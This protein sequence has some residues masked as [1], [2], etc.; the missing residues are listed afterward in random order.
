[1]ISRTDGMALLIHHVASGQAFFSGVALIL[2]AVASASAGC[3]W[4]I[5]RP[6]SPEPSR[7]EIAICVGQRGFPIVDTVLALADLAGVVYVASE[8]NIDAKGTRIV[9]GT[10]LA[11]LWALSAEYG[12]RLTGE[13]RAAQEQR[14]VSTT[15]AGAS[16]HA[17]GPTA[18]TGRGQPAASA[19]SHSFAG[20]GQPADS[21]LATTD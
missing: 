6:L 4:L 16:S 7:R 14:L 5:V 2:L 15:G 8:D 1:M 20:P 13:C 18:A 12:Y 11:A 21:A 9:F 10:S 17:A 19:G 3:S